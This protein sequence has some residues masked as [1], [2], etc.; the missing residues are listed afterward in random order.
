MALVIE[1]YIIFVRQ[2]CAIL[3]RFG[4]ILVP[5]WLHFEALG[6][7]GG[8]LGGC[9][10]PTGVPGGLARAPRGPLG[11]QME[12]M[13]VYRFSGRAVFGAKMPSKSMLSS[14]LSKM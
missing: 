7:P 10:G 6:G 9:L 5:F 4:S 12:A 3:P 2:F 11:G 13:S 1:I 8:C 14:K